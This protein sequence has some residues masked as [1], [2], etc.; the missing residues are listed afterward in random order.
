[1]IEREEFLRWQCRLRQM[2]MREDG[3]RPSPGMTASV[4]LGG[5]IELIKAMNIVLVPEDPAESTAFFRFQIKKSHDPKQVLEKGLQFLQSTYYHHAPSF[6]DEM[7]A[8]FANNSN[9]AAQL[10]EAGQ[11]LL[12]FAQFNQVFKLVCTLRQLDAEEDGWQATY[13]HNN[14]FN[15][16][17]PG[18]AT[19]I[20]FTPNWEKSVV[21]EGELRG[22]TSSR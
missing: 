3:G 2:A 6:R 17:L 9:A 12:Q 13:W 1:M 5:G 4:W 11:C 20:G 14:M 22:V 21:E 7:T 18:N 8:L 10:L 19:I 16:N 15:A